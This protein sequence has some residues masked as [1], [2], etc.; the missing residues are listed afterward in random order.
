MTKRERESIPLP[1]IYRQ[2]DTVYI[3]GTFKSSS[4]LLYQ[5]FTVH[6]VFNKQLFPLV[7]SLLPNK[8]APL[9][10]A[11]SKSKGNPARRMASAS[12]LQPDFEGGIIC[13]IA[14]QFPEAHHPGAFTI[15]HK[16]HGELSK[17]VGCKCSTPAVINFVCSFGS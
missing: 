2:A 5:Q 9:T 11:S 14:L 7:Y 1:R 4:Q 13:S 17:A 15:S 12:I 3:N 10:I 6:G 8:T 16:Q